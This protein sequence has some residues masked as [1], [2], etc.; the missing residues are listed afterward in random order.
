[1]YNII[2]YD[3]RFL[4]NLYS[5]RN[6]NCNL[7]QCSVYIEAINNYFKKEGAALYTIHMIKIPTFCYAVL[8]GSCSAGDLKT[9]SDIDLLIVTKQKLL[10]R[11]LCSHIREKIDQAL[12]QF[13]ISADI[14][15]YT[16]QTLLTDNSVFTVNL[17]TCGKILI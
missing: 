15:F 13:Q 1:M 16:E 2:L 5:S 3:I 4:S 7:R 10:N 6:S 14:V 17:R 11:E 9:S 12:E 8:F